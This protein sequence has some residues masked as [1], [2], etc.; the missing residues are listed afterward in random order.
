M[1]EY[2]NPAFLSGS[3]YRSD[4]S[5]VRAR[6]ASYVCPSYDSSRKSY[7]NFASSSMQLGCSGDYSAN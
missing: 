1:I 3:E 4:G 5:I 7:E 2:T 6:P